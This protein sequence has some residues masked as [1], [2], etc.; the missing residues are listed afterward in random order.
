MLNNAVRQHDSLGILEGRRR[1]TSIDEALR[2]VRSA[3]A[4]RG[5]AL[6]PTSATFGVDDGGTLLAVMDSGSVVDGV[7]MQFDWY[8]RRGG[9]EV[10]ASF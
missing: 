7:T 6:A 1:I 2:L 10:W 4:D 8:I 5:Y 3:V 9:F